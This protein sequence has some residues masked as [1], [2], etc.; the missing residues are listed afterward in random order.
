MS[1]FRL[2]SN[3]AK[4]RHASRA[5]VGSIQARPVPGDGD[6]RRLADRFGRTIDH[7]RLSVTSACNLRC[8]YCRPVCGSLVKAARLTDAQRLELIRFFYS[9]YGLK[10]LRLTGGEPLLHPTIVRLTASIKSLAPDLALAMT[11][12]ASRLGPVA[13]D[14]RAA[15]L[16]RL[17]ISLDT[18]DPRIY[19]K[20][21]DGELAPVLQGIE[22]A[23]AMGFPPPKLNT[24]V[25][26]GVN[27]H[28]LPDLAAWAF[29]RNIEI[30]FLEAMPIGPAA[31][32]NREHFVGAAEIRRRLCRSLNLVAVPRQDGE[33]AVRYAATG[34]GLRGTL[35]IIA[36]VTE[37]FCGQ[38][39]RMRVTADGRLFPCLL[40]SRSVDLSSCWEK[41]AFQPHKVDDLIRRA[42]EAKSASG[43]LH[44]ETAMI[45][46]GG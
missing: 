28:Q 13:A 4:A 19:R 24:V 17:N 29:E 30:R 9:R 33:T 7:L 34:P 26:A 1:P 36:P 10:Q 5:S 3:E 20:L 38:C 22:R 31:P 15:G 16:D 14:L 32:F 23:M 44:Q 21:T 39:R 46:L 18:I 45:A 25:L 11:T 40:D 43:L 27:D 2:V 35:G 42:V 12:N 37:P 8:L 41:A 6:R